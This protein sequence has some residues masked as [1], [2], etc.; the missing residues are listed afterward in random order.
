MCLAI[1]AEVVEVTEDETAV[2]DFGGAKKRVSLALV[3]DVER[4]DFVLVHAG[5]AIEKVDAEEALKTRELF[6]ELERLNEAN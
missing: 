3:D 6:E 2:V 4:G 1:P 5:F